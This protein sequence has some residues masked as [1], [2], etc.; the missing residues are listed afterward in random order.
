[1]DKVALF[2]NKLVERGHDRSKVN[3]IT[4]KVNFDNRDK[5]LESGGYDKVPRKDKIPLVLVTTYTPYIRTHDLKAALLKHWHK[6]ERHSE[7]NVLFPNPPLLAFKRA[8]N[9]AD[10]LVKSKLPVIAERHEIKEHNLPVSH[11]GSLPS[12]AVP[13]P[14]KESNALEW[15][16]KDQDLLRCLF[17]L[18]NE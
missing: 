4:D 5:Y 13:S 16:E 8:R 9:L 14:N 17:D 3:E 10:M 7:L 2:T 1:M 12:S 18:M 6:I 15:T 11:Q